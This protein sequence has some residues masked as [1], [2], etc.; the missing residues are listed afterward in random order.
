MSV[1]HTHYQGSG[2]VP[3]HQKGAA[4]AS[5]SLGVNRANG[6]SW[7]C[8]SRDVP[9][10]GLAHG[11][12]V[13][14]IPSLHLSVSFPVQSDSIISRRQCRRPWSN[15]KSPQQYAAVSRL[16]QLCR[17]RPKLLSSLTA[18]SCWCEAPFWGMHK[19]R[20]ASAQTPGYHRG[21]THLSCWQFGRWWFI[22]TVSSF[23]LAVHHVM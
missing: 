19:C 3:S 20:W 5:L 10:Q 13:E 2:Y 1:V 8:N 7:P 23:K 15:R 14:S 9:Q 22:M 6:V 17:R 16:S 18:A 4:L 21:S 11:H 12:S